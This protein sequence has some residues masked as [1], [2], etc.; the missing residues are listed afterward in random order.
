[1]NPFIHLLGSSLIQWMIV[2]IDE[3]QEPQQDL[4]VRLGKGGE[5]R[6]GE[7]LLSLGGLESAETLGSGLP[8]GSDLRLGVHSYA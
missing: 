7:A 1:M 3:R 2:R 4:L 5:V 8:R 6:L